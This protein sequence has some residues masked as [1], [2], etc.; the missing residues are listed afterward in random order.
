M[1]ASRGHGNEGRAPD[2]SPAPRS[3]APGGS[4]PPRCASFPCVGAG[5]RRLIPVP[6]RDRPLSHAR[7]R[8]CIRHAAP[9]RVALRPA[10]WRAGETGSFGGELRVGRMVLFAMR[11]GGTGAALNG[12]PLRRF[13]P[14]RVGGTLAR[15]RVLPFSSFPRMRKRG[16]NFLLRLPRGSSRYRPRQA[17]P[18]RLS[19]RTPGFQPG[20][21]GSTPL[22]A[23]S[24]SPQHMSDRTEA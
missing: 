6:R 15:L 1:R 2:R 24:A 18:V 3:P 8:D 7:G 16:R 13:F 5:L 19:V 4:W 9:R 14:T 21:R 17:R 11:V 20:K 10:G 23:A 12:R 22:R